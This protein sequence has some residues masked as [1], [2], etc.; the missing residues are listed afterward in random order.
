[1]ETIAEDPASQKDLLERALM[2]ENKARKAITCIDD[3]LL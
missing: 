1:M 2:A 3:L